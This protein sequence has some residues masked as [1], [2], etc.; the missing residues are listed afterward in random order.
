MTKVKRFVKNNSLLVTNIIIISIGLFI[1]LIMTFF[2]FNSIVKDDM[3]T[4]THALFDGIYTS[5]DDRISY[6]AH[7]TKTMS[8][9]YFLQNM[10][11]QEDEIAED[12]FEKMMS[13][14]LANVS[15]VNNW[16]G[17]YLISCNSNKYYTPDGVGKVVD[18]SKDEYDI[19]YDNFIKTGI[20]YGADLTY[21]Q[22]N[23]Q[24]YVIFIDRRMEVNGELKA[25]L[26]CAMYL[27]DVTDIMKE[28]SEKYNV[29]ICFT[30]TYGKTTL[31]ED[32]VN[33]G[34][35]YYSRDYTEDMI[36]Q[37]QIY[38]KEGFI[39]RKYIPDL[40]MYLVVK[41]KQLILSKRFIKFL[42]ITIVYAFIM[43]LILTILNFQRFKG[44]KDV[45][46]TKVRTDFLT[47][48]SNRNGLESSIN[49]FMDE[50]GSEMIGG[51]MFILDIDHFKEVNDTL[52]HSFGDEVLMKF[53]RELSKC[54]RGGDIV[55]RLGGDEFMVF[56]PS[57][58]DKRNITQKANELIKALNFTI[59]K[60]DITVDIS[61]SI[62]IS[63][64]PINGE[65]YDEL[66]ETADKA[67][68]YA[69]KHGRNG[70]NLY[71][72]IE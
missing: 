62:G 21:D 63:I 3:E 59:D 41:N 49:F 22:F 37:N 26:G 47:K 71:S 32:D 70:F 48:I 4:T 30:D 31:D 2:I 19:W 53:A 50:D 43:I 34:I 42:V 36:K 58:T 67:L 33:V 55:G 11:E 69:K 8:N 28:Y 27:S 17:A 45:L 52:G 66:Y 64:Y 57:L 68:Y 56:S 54:F 60:D 23:E 72:D 18:S 9:D 29:D 39:I 25:V 6:S 7:F 14:Y 12:E 10:L 24:K 44:E 46:K 35:A 20:E 51:A 16:E 5:I 61:S 1:G 40:G 15:D 13:E 65:T 38:T